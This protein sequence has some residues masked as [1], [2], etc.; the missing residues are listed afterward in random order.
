MSDIRRFFE[1]ELMALRE[2]G[3]EFAKVFPEAAR[4]LDSGNAEDRDPYVERL[5]EGVAFLTARIREAQE[6]E[7]DGLTRH[8]LEIV[9]PDLEQPLPSVA[10]LQFAPRSD[11]AE[12]TTLAAGTIVMAT[13]ERASILSPFRFV[14]P[15]A[16]EQVEVRSARLETTDANKAFLDLEFAKVSQDKDRPWPDSLSVFLLGDAPVVWAMRFALLR[17][18]ARI[19]VLREGAWIASTALAVSRLDQ[20]GYASDQ[21]IPSSLAEVRDFLCADERFRFLAI[22]GLSRGGAS[23]KIRLRIHFEG[24]FPRG[25]ARGVSTDLFRL[26]TGVAVN[27][28]VESCQALSWDHTQSTMVLRAQGGIQREILDVVAVEGRTSSH[29]PRR[30]AYRRFSSYRHGTAAPH[31]QMV[32]DV[33]RN[34]RSVVGL[35]IGTTGFE[36]P[37]ENQFLAI[38]AVCSDGD[39]PHENLQAATFQNLAMESPP[40]VSIAGLTR[41][42]RSFRPPPQADPRSRL[43]AFAAGHFEGWMDAV[44]LKDGLRHLM[45]EPSESKRTLI[46]SIQDVSM[47]HGHVL[48]KGV[49]WRTMTVAIRMR[50][51]T[52]TPDTWDRLGVIDAFGSALFKIV[53]EE[54]PIGSRTRMRIVVEPAGIELEWEE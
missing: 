44:R 13:G 35:S 38:Q 3:G 51:T 2:E 15:V 30:I 17:R 23:P 11:F 49:A 9:A 46:E 14:G 7:Q 43:L 6:A 33:D 16:I 27:R 34:G 28:F 29:P 25:T 31:F 18:L 41:P 50:D 42:T 1:R 12:P 20:P 4:Y 54:T 32:R 22:S 19:E 10:V 45:W 39:H 40:R 8:L 47:E 36:E 37:I 52:C 24:D 21:T 48:A 53:R 26:N 5:T